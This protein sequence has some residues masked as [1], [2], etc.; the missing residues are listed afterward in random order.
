MKSTRWMTGVAMMAG[1]LQ[2]AVP[3]ATPTPRPASAAR[4]PELVAQMAPVYVTAIASNMKVTMRYKAIALGDR[5]LFSL[6]IEEVRKKSAAERAGLTRGM[7]IVEIEGVPLDGLYDEEFEKLM[8]RQLGDYLTLKVT[9]VRRYFSTKPFAVRIT[10]PQS[11]P[12]VSTVM[13]VPELSV[14]APAPKQK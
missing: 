4:Q 11:S 10:L 2:G 13:N 5:Q 3:T 6:R 7:E 12:M 8:R 1:L 9:T 14:P